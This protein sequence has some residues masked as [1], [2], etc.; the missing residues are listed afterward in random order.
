VCSNIAAM[1]SVNDFGDRPA[2][3]L[4]DGEAL[5]LSRPARHQPCAAL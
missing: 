1:V 2:R 3:L 4:V 5:S